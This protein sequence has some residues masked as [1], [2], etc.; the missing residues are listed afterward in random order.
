M[1]KSD[2]QLIFVHKTIVTNKSVRRTYKS[3]YI[4]Y[5]KLY[6]ILHLVILP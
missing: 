1:T 5:I 3:A 6:V 2:S 4:K